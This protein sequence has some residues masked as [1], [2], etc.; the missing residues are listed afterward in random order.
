MK[1]GHRG[2]RARRSR[3]LVSLLPQKFE[4]RGEIQQMRVSIEYQKLKLQPV[5]NSTMG[6][7]LKAFSCH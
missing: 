2:K 4:V 6:L 3:S 5:L 1:G 7:Y